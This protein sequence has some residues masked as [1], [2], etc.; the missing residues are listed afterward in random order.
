MSVKLPPCT[1]VHMPQA[2][3]RTTRM[4]HPTTGGPSPW[5]PPPQRL[6]LLHPTP[7]PSSPHAPEPA[8]PWSPHHPYRIY[9]QYPSSS[10]NSQCAPI[11]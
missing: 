5:R 2:P 3:Y 8:D 1:R 11:N 7:S 9:G 10:A 6:H 4:P